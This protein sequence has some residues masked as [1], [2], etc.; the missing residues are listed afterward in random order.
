MRSMKKLSRFAAALGCISALA[1][2][3]C[4]GS[5]GVAPSAGSS[6]TQLQ[7]HGGL[8]F[9]PGWVQ[10]DGVL[11]HVPHYMGTVH[12]ANRQVQ[13]DILL[14]YYGGP[15]LTTPT[16][17][18]IFWGYTKYGDSNNVKPLLTSYFGNMGG[19]SHN[20]IYTQYY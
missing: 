7:A 1:M 9:G 4:A 5:S 12:Q 20:N 14:T 11:Y 2:A 10:K 17:Y 15:V 18:V 13:P 8:T 19:S 6:T 3:G 16:T